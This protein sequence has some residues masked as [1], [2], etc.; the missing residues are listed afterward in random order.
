MQLVEQLVL[1]FKQEAGH[2]R[3]VLERISE[4]K[5]NWRPHSK[6]WTM[7]ELATHIANV[8]SW[9]PM[10]IANDSMNIDPSNVSAQKTVAAQTLQ[11]ILDRFDKNC[12]EAE[13][14]LAQSSEEHLFTPWTMQSGEKVLFKMPRLSVLRNFILNHLIHHRAQMCVYLRLNGLPVPAIYGPTA[15][16]SG[17]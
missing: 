17:M 6:S 8:P 13:S 3:K 11:E 1:E 5:W 4:D 12:M 9:A 7:G 14:A 2:T 16:E 15:D 10:T